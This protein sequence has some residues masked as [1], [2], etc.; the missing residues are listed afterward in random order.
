MRRVMFA[1]MGSWLFVCLTIPAHAADYSRG[2]VWNGNGCCQERVVTQQTELVYAPFT[3]FPYVVPPHPVY[4][5]DPEPHRVVH[6]KKYNS[7]ANAA[8]ARCHWRE[9]PVRVDRG[10]WVWGGKTTCY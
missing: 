6:F 9:A 10:L 2:Y 4:V 5:D 3:A 1:L 8:A 7:Y